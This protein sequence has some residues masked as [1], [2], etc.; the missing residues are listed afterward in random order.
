MAILNRLIPNAWADFLLT[1]QNKNTARFAVDNQQ[2]SFEANL[3]FKFFDDCSGADA[4]ADTDILIYRFTT[5]YPLKLQLRLI[6][7]WAGGRKYIVYPFTG[8]EAI[9][10]GSWADVTSTKLSPINNDLSVSGLDSHP[11]SGV[12]IEKR[13]ATAFSTTAPKRTGTSYLVPTSGGGS[14]AASSYTASGNASGVAAGNTFLLVF[15]NI[16]G[17]TDSEFLYQLEWEERQ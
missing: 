11:T 1:T 5:V 15:T 8:S 17:T 7:G 9:S 10:G 13:I 14:R 16:N 4:I 12:T 3:Q 6:N 2:S